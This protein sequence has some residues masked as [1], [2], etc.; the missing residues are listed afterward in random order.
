VSNGY[1]VNKANRM[2]PEVFQEEGYTTAGFSAAIALSE[3]LNFSQGFDR[4]DQDPEIFSNHIEAN[5]MARRA[6]EITDAAIEYLGEG[7][8]PEPFF[9][10]LHYVDPHSPYDPPEPYRSLYGEISA[11]VIGNEATLRRARDKSARQQGELPREIDLKLA[12]LY[13]GEVSYTDHEVGRFLRAL[14]ET[15]NYDDALIVITADHGET[16]WEH[17]DPWSHGFATYETTVSIP[18]I[19]RYPG[20][21]HA[22][23]RVNASV[24][25]IDLMPTLL[26]FLEI[27]LPTPIDGEDL[28][29]LLA[30]GR[31]DRGASFSQAPLPGGKFEQKARLWKNER[32]T[33]SVRMGRWKYTRSPRQ[34]LEELYDLE[35]DPGENENLL[36]TSPERVQ[37]PHRKLA[38]A[39][40]KHLA[41]ASPLPSRFFPRAGP[42]HDPDAAARRTMRKQLKAMGYLSEEDEEEEGGLSESSEDSSM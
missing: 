16:F 3:L 17:S 36:K 33:H 18:L 30:G 35:A 23:T 39:L 8:R 22:G 20:G 37:Q 5:R 4:W 31:P 6:G 26:R 7:L 19:V 14:Q 9:L 1:T 25:N 24:S 27:D 40:T 28:S 11:E 29:P 12:S 13:A 10:F 41:S 15:G 38:A 2:L 34:K 42:P 21:A 32:K